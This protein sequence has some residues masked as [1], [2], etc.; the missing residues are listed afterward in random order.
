LVGADPLFDNVTERPQSL[1]RA[2]SEAVNRRRR[3][4][5]WA[6]FVALALLC[7]LFYAI[8]LVKLSKS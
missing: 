7:L 8:T 2:E 1:S 6:I 3:G 4:R 5:N